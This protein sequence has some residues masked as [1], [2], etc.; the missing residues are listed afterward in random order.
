MWLNMAK[1]LVQIEFKIGMSQGS[2]KCVDTKHTFEQNASNKIQKNN[3][4]I[5]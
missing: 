5:R 4:K 2:P 3:G 1:K